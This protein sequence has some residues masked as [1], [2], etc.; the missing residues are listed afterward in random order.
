MESD[1]LP[2]EPAAYD[3]LRAALT[4]DGPLA[5]A[6][7]LADELQVA[8]DYQGLFYALLLKARVELGVPP[9]PTGPA[10]DLPAETHERY[11]QAIVEAG[12]KVGGLL[13]EKGELNKASGF[14]RLI[15][16][17]EPM[18]AAL[19]AYTPGPDDDTYGIVEIAW[20]HGVHPKKGFDLILDRHG[21]C[22]AI[23]MVGS[24]DLSQRPEV[25]D[26]CV[27]RLI[28]ALSEQL[29]ERLLGDL[30][31]RG[32]SVADTATVPELLAADPELFADDMYH[33]DTSHLNSVVQYAGQL[34]PCDE[35][36]LAIQLS[37]YGERL[38][39]SL[40]GDAAP[41]FEN[42]Y[43]D[44]TPYLKVL[45]GIDVEAGLKHFHAKLAPAAE[46]GDTYPAEMLVN[47]YLRLERLTD[48]LAVAKDHLA[49]TG[50]QE[51][52]C[53]PLVELARRAKDFA[54]LA[55][56]AKANADPVNYLA[57]LIAGQ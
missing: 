45:A 54:A 40:R 6:D 21:V 42:T 10:S 19:V 25:R 4:A 37:E 8:E 34:P 11:E 41:P 55:D 20:Q 29:R 5:A 53:P 48:A 28:V 26:Y 36:K 16:E 31:H 9:F 18:R 46:I 7:K 17:T 23:T 12:R 38:S 57:G 33:I 30:R 49:N 24:A 32:V 35:L 56:A 50:G 52:S 3:R 2:L 27:K 43:A 1:T 44:Y 39:L 22:S 47:L 51:L 15:G 14:F 13:L